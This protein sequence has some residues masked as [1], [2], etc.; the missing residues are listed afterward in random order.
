ML[1]IIGMLFVLIGYWLCYMVEEVFVVVL[2]V[3]YDELVVLLLFV[4]V[5]C[6]YG[7]VVFVGFGVMIGGMLIYYI[8][9][10]YMVIYGV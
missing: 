10:F 6:Y 4:D 3:V 5:L 7:K 2:V 9:V 8:I 1:F